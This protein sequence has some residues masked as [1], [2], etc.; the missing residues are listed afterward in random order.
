MVVRTSIIYHDALKCF[1]KLYVDD[2][3]FGSYY[4][5]RIHYVKMTDFPEK[6]Y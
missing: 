4:L 2:M 6:I 1:Y 3:M 5:L